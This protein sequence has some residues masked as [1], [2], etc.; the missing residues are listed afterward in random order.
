MK[1]FHTI[2]FKHA[3]TG[4]AHTFV[5]QPNLRIHLTIALLVLVSGWWLGI[6]RIEWIILLFTIMWVLVSEMIN[7]VIE[8]ISDLLT[9]EYHRSVKIAKDVAA[10]M[11]LVGAIGA[12]IIGFIIFTPYLLK[13]FFS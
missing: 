13:L 6:T 5:S 11:V 1:R 3:F 4:L 7:T 9:T 2:S 8:A 10:G 12:V